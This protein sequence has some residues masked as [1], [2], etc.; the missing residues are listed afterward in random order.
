MMRERIFGLTKIFSNNNGCAIESEDI[1]AATGEARPAENI[2]RFADYSP[3]GVV[4]NGLTAAIRSTA[5]LSA[6]E[7]L[8]SSATD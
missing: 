2:D 8:R 6:C 1:S 4:S 3:Y 5:R 7:S